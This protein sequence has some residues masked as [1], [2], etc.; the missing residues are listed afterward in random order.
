M[1][2]DRRGSTP[3]SILFLIRVNSRL[4]AAK[5]LFVIPIK[6]ISKLRL[7]LAL[8]LLAPLLDGF[9]PLLQNENTCGMA[10]CRNSKSCCHKSKASPATERWTAPPAC[11]SGCAQHSGLAASSS[12]T[13]V[14]GNLKITPILRSTV[15]QRPANPLVDRPI[16]EFAL[17]E[18]PPPV[19]GHT[20]CPE[21]AQEEKIET[22]SHLQNFDLN[23]ARGDS[24]RPGIRQLR[25]HQRTRN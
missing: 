5:D 1:A 15:I 18:R 6:T 14:A 25:Q 21:P 24:I 13:V 22:I 16:T 3:I 8:I 19:P 20:R 4:S 10:C 7:V 11:P 12:P 23:V 9:A 17:F 2:A